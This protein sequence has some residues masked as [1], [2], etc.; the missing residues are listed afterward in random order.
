MHQMRL[1]Q[2]A[3]FARFSASEWGG[4]HAGHDEVYYNENREI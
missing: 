2:N 3:P 1:G 4:E